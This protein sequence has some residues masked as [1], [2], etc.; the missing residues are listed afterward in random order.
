M[1]HTKH[2]QGNYIFYTFYVFV[3]ECGFYG[4]IPLFRLFS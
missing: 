1:L 2:L 3:K 4:Q